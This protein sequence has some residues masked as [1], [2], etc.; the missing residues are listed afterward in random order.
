MGRFVFSLVLAMPWAFA[1]AAGQNAPGPFDTTVKS[2]IE[3]HCIDCHGPD[4]Q[5]AGL[6]LDI[7]A[8]D[9]QDEKTSGTWIAVFDKVTAGEMPPKKRPRP[10]Q[11]DLD[12]ATQF[13]HA[14]LYTASL[15]RQ[16]K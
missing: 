13:L 5:K 2:L 6:R 12:A 1:N 11:R 7:L 8:A 3:G 15:Q 16:Q 4:V 10:P 9:F 14:Q